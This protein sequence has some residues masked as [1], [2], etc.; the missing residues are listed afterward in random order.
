MKALLSTARNFNKET[1]Q[2]CGGLLTALL[3]YTHIF[4]LVLGVEAVLQE[5]VRGAKE[6]LQGHLHHHQQEQ[7]QQLEA[8]NKRK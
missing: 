4:V 3:L 1:L 8:G 5:Q 2:L 6:G 7:Q